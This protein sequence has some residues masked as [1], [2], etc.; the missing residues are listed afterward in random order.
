MKAINIKQLLI[1][2]VCAL[3]TSVQAATYTPATVPSPKVAG[4]EYYVSNPDTILNTDDVAYINQCCRMLEDT[5]DVEMAVVVLGSIGDYEI[6]DFG[7]E[8]GNRWGIGKE[9]KNTGVL[10]TFAL[11]S[12]QVFIHTGSGIE[13]VLPD[14][15]CKMIIQNDMVPRFK[16]GDYGG[17]LC[18]AVTHVYTICT[19]GDAPEELLNMA[20]SLGYQ[21]SD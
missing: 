21:L 1:G 20:K 12:R 8:L 18:A 4:Q 15:T 5:T 9:G 16:Q 10:I 19:K 17:G 11:A 3:C 14:A 7:L 6:F 13:G 2:I